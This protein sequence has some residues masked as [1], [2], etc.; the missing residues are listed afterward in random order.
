MTHLVDIICEIPHVQVSDCAF[1]PHYA[2]LRVTIKMH[3]KEFPIDI[4]MNYLLHGSAFP[5][6]T[7]R[8][9]ITRVF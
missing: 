2:M 7:E 8:E 1:G 6:I 4:A 3:I 9:H 5:P